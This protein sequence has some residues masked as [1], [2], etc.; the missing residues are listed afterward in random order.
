VTPEEL[1][2]AARRLIR[3]GV[4]NLNFV[5]PDH[6]LPH[7]LWLCRRLRQEGA[8]VPFVY[9]CSGYMKPELVDS[10]AEVVDVFM[11]DFKFADPDLAEM[12]MGDARYPDLAL[13]SIRRMFE[14]KGPLR[15][16]DVS[17]RA[18]AERGVLVRHLV[19]PGHVENSLQVLRL[20]HREIG[21]EL[22]LSL[23]S[24]YHPVPECIRRGRLTRRL[25][26][27]EYRRVVEEAGRLG[28]EDAYIQPDFG[29]PDYLP[30]FERENPFPEK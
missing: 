5:T 8:A 22:T 11:P 20:L 12:C 6:F 16:F 27:N 13:A 30:D 23:M 26:S 1:L 9:N 18:P 4:H 15:P 7:V 2:D 28:F 17:G 24:Q 19:L 10:I 29:D 25:R 14:L 3:R 21:P